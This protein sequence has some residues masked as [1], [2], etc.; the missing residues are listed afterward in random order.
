MLIR[1]TINVFL[2]Q[3]VRPEF[4]IFHL[5]RSTFLVCG[6]VGLLF[7]T[8]L[9]T[10]LV[11]FLGLSPWV[12]GAIVLV[13]VLTFLGLVT[14]TKV[15]TGEEKII[16]YH[17][18]IAVL[19]STAL[20]LRLL[21]QPVLPYLGVTLLGIGLFMA[22]GR[23]GCLMVGCCHGKPHRWGV[24][25]R[26]AHAAA[27][28]PD[29]LV[30]V[31][32]FPIQLIESIWVFGV[33][34]IGAFLITNGRSPGDAL[35]W[36]IIAYD[37]ARFCFEFLRGDAARPYRWGFSEPQWISL[38][39]MCPIIWA[40]LSGVLP[41]HRWHVAA[42][43]GMVLAMITISLSRHFRKTAKHQL[44][45]PRHIR[46]VAEAVDL[47]SSLA[48]QQAAF[49]EQKSACKAIHLA[50]TSLGIQISAGKIKDVAGQIDYFTLSSQPDPMTPETASIISALILQLRYSSNPNQVVQ[51]KQ[52]IYHLLINPGH[53]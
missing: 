15:I 26:A 10:S 50:Y 2:D 1:K 8:L 41:L 7:A 44:L 3:L 19:V 37:S 20:L 35:A 29:Y 48:L 47:V 6:Y 23:L 17:H 18:E 52:G 4:H 16:Y 21:D 39:L 40:E 31:R 24:C 49:P 12:M 32:L 38:L 42:M 43:G 27:G 46:E 33:V 11:S 14:A 22:C 51:G 25:Y 28:F 53:P 30:G 36:Y 9:A 45:H 13:A 34:I 5:T